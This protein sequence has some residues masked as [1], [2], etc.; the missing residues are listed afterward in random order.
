[1]VHFRDVFLLFLLIFLPQDLLELVFK[2]VLYVKLD[3]SEV[4]IAFVFQDL[5][6]KCDL[7]IIMKVG[8]DSLYDLT[9]PL[10]DKCLQPILLI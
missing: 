5:G 1:M 3:V 10:D 9:G 7:V 4:F 8:L 2:G 6:K